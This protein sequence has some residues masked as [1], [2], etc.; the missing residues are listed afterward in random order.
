VIGIEAV[1]LNFSYVND[2]NIINDCSFSIEKGKI[3]CLLGRNGSG[4]TTLLRLLNGHLKA[5]SG[6]IR[7]DGYDVEKASRRTMA[8]IIGFVPQEHSGIFAYTAQDMVVMGRTPHLSTFSRPQEKDYEIA[9]KALQAVGMAHMKE[10]CYMEISG[11]ERQLIF[12]ARAIAQDAS[13][14]ILDEPTSHLD[15]TN[16]QGIMLVLQRIVKEKGCG[17]IMAMHDPNL[18][19]SF[20]DEMIKNGCI[21]Q[22]GPTS[23]IM[24]EENLTELY[25]M[26]I[27]IT[28]LEEGRRLVYIE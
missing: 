6:K 16:Q 1:N 5:D 15:F 27:K 8:R 22:Q 19:M 21:L 10:R 14:Y 11:G 3:Y 28:C 18:T 23:T 13:Y 4:K 20:A 12:L 17:A 26:N 25:G 2:N 24:T 7:V 9:E